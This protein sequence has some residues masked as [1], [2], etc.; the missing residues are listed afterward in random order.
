MANLETLEIQIAGNAEGASQNIDALI[1]SLSSLSR[2]V[3]RS[4]SGLMRLNAELKTLKSFGVKVPN[5]GKVS[6]AEQVRKSTEVAKK[7]LEEVKEISKK[8][9]E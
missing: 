9:S 6:G 3:G 4:V 1:H 7:R 5:I 2:A 8:T